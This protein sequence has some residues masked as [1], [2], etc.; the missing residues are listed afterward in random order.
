MT[1][2]HT[3]ILPTMDDGARDV[4][5]SLAMLA[6]QRV[7]RVERVALTPHF[8][9]DEERPERFLARRKKSWDKLRLA[10]EQSGEG[11][12][13][14]V[15]GAEVTWVPGLHRWDELRQLCY[16]QSSYLLLELPDSPWRGSMIDQIYDMMD[17]SGVTP[18]LA[19]LERYFRTQKPDYIR[20]LFRMGVPVQISAEPMLHLFQRGKVLGNIRGNPNCMLISDCH[21]LTARRP[22]LGPG[23]AQIEKNL[24]RETVS[25][26]RSSS[27]RIFELAAGK[28][29]CYASK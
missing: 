9:R 23:M 16:G 15:L 5:M 21:N 12:P 2:L 11:F 13:D 3:H 7:Q 8:Y 4:E 26:M 28:E 19:H 1:D 22:N 6:E 10:M 29:K 17:S 24:S 18:V 20:E 27:R 14:L 25:A